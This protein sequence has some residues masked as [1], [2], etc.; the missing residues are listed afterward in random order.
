M[1]SLFSFKI[2]TQRQLKQLAIIKQT[3][4]QYLRLTFVNVGAF[5]PFYSNSFAFF[6]KKLLK[7]TKSCKNK[8]YLQEIIKSRN[9][10]F[11]SL[12]GDKTYNSFVCGNIT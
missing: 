9:K 11:V 5:A 7:F 3:I 1:C 4:H 10:F 8:I 6:L 2:Y 12:H